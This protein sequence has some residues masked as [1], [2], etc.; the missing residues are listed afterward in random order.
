MAAFVRTGFT[1]NHRNISPDA[2]QI[3]LEA[4]AGGS[5]LNRK[6]L[7]QLLRQPDFVILGT[8][9]TNTAAASSPV[10][11]LNNEGGV[12]FPANS[13]RDIVVFTEAVNGANRYR[14]SCAYRVLGGTDPTLKG[15]ERYLTDC[16]ARYVATTDGATTSVEVAAECVGPEWW[17][18]AAPVAGAFASGVATVQWLGTN[19]P[20]RF[21]TPLTCNNNL[22][23]AMSAEVFNAMLQRNISLANGTSELDG[24]DVIGTEGVGIGAG[25]I[26]ASA[27]MTPP[28]HSPLLINTT[29]APDEVTLGALGLSADLVTWTFRVFVGPILD[30]P[31]L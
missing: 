7:Q 30:L 12:A 14:Y 22:T 4:Y 2:R 8:T 27:Y 17:D 31:L 19:A 13:E 26:E 9:D 16:V 29:P 5:E 28:V 23:A 10:L 25:R 21:L 3:L 6:S 20:V 11:A 24:A 18:G 15:V 1:N